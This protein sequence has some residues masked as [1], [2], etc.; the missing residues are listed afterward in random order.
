MTED[1][2]RDILIDIGYSKIAVRL[3]EDV[4]GCTLLWNTCTPGRWDHVGMLRPQL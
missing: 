4:L 2:V 3:L 1:Q